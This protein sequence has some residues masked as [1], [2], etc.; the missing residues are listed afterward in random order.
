MQYRDV[1]LREMVRI[2]LLIALG[3]AF[4]FVLSYV[5]SDISA[6]LQ[7]VAFSAFVAYMFYPLTL[8]LRRRGVPKVLSILLVY[9]VFIGFIVI[10]SIYVFPV[11]ISEFT[12]LGEKMPQYAA[13]IQSWIR[14]AQGQYQRINIPDVVQENIDQNLA[15]A[16]QMLVRMAQGVVEFIIDLFGKLF[17]IILAPVMAFY[18]L[19]DLDDLKGMVRNILPKPYLSPVYDVSQRINKI[20][21]RWIRAQLFINSLILLLV[22]VGLRIIGMNFALVLAIITGVANWIPYFGPLIGALAAVLLALAQGWPMVFKVLILY[23]IV[24]QIANN[25][26][27][28]QI[29]GYSMGLHPVVVILALLMGAAM[30]GFLGLLLAVPVAGVLKVVVE[31]YLEQRTASDN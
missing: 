6:I 15:G 28:P 17:I 23:L 19:R 16:Q 5:W 14:S 13:Q 21:G 26:L 9:V 18:M 8:H 31:Y 27:E 25:V 29:L 7:P 1:S 20:L 30:A 24:Q 11:L 12:V 4:V 3:M 22:Y 10:I 2:I